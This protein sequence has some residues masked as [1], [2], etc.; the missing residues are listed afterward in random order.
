MAR[1]TFHCST[2]QNSRNKR[3]GYSLCYKDKEKTLKGIE[4]PIV[5]LKPTEKL[6]MTL[7]SYSYNWVVSWMAHFG[8]TAKS[9]VRWLVRMSL[10]LTQ[11]LQFWVRTA[12]LS[13]KKKKKGR[14]KKR[15]YKTFMCWVCQNK[16]T[17][18]LY[19]AAMS[20]QRINLISNTYAYFSFRL[21]NILYW[22]SEFLV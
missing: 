6:V 5:E 15:G 1:R 22:N 21:L 7:A 16:P 17:N 20:T 10:W 11:D 13:E 2:N 8:E 3:R 14:K 18:H 4:P 19:N 9:Q 12:A